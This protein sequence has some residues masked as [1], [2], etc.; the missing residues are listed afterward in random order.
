MHFS[1]WQELPAEYWDEE[2]ERRWD[3]FLE[4]RRIVAKGLELA[5]TAK[6]IGG[7]NEARLVLYADQAKGCP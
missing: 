5:R 4:I 1:T 7:A 3:E 6:V 2:L